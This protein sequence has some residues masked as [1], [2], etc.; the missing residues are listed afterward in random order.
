MNHLENNSRVPE[1]EY[2][3]PC[4]NIVM[5]LLKALLGNGS[6]NTFQHTRHATTEVFSMLGS[7]QRQWTGWVAITWEPQQ[8]RTQK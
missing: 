3:S 2:I 4:Q 1:M 6:V 7:R 5:D 8:T